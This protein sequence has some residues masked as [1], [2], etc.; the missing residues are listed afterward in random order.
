MATATAAGEGRKTAANS[1]APP[2][3]PSSSA[4][5][6]RATQERD[7]RR[8]ALRASNLETW[9]SGPS[10]PTG[11]L[12]SSLKKNTA[13]VKR[14]KQGLGLENRD[15]AIKEIA[16]LNLDKYVEEVVQM[17][18]EGLSRCSSAKDYLAAA[19]VL[20]A[21]HKRFGPSA[22]SVPLTDL[23][24]S[25][26]SPPSKAVLQ[27]ISAEQR[28]RD[29][30]SRVQR[31]KGLLRVV[32]ELA[33]VQLVGG[34]DKQRDQHASI[35]WL[36]RIIKDLLSNDREHANIPIL[37]TLLKALGATL[38]SP[39]NVA[40][41]TPAEAQAEPSPDQLPELVTF[42][43]KDRLQKLLATYFE[44]LRRRIVREHAR[45]Q[46]Q[47]RRNHEAY[48]RSGEIFEDRQQN[49]EKTTKSFEK[50]LDS[51]RQLAELLNLPMPK[52]AESVQS[53]SIGLNLDAK[54]AFER[55]D[56]DYSSG[57]LPWEDEDTRRFYEDVPDLRDQVPMDLLLAGSN[58]VLNAKLS[59][60]GWDDKTKGENDNAAEASGVA[61]DEME[62]VEHEDGDATPK[63]NGSPPGSPRS[64]LEEIAVDHDEP[65]ITPTTDT[66][67]EE[68]GS[69]SA[70]MN[71]LLMRLPELTSRD[72]IDG[73]AIEFGFLNTKANRGRMMRTLSQMYKN[74]SDLPPYYARLV[75][76]L[77]KYMPD[78]GSGVVAWL[79]DEFRV[80]HKRRLSEWTEKRA[81]NAQYLGELTKFKVCPIHVIFHCLKVCL[82]DF[83]TYTI[84]TLSILL[85]T[86]GRFL[87]RTEQT[88]ER[89]K[90]ALELLRRKRAA[91]HI[92][93][94]FLLLLD[95]AYYFCNPPERKAVEQK[96]RPPIEQY[97]RHLFYDMLSRKTLE[98]VLK[99]LRK[100]AWDD[101]AVRK[102]LF[103]AF[104]KPWRIKFGN[105]HLLA[106]LL[107]ELQTYHP[108]FVIEVLEQ[109]CEDVVTGLE[110]NV[111]Q[112]NQ[113]RVAVVRYFGELY[114]YRL[115]NSKMIFDQ[116]WSFTT[117]GHPYGRPLPGQFTPLDA[118]DDYFRIRLI[119]TLLDTCGACFD[120]GSLKRRLDSFL[121]F[122]NLY[123]LS[124]TQPLPM[125]IDFM[126]SDTLEALRPKLV[127]KTEFE[128]VAVAV[129]QMFALQRA[130]EA[131]ATTAVVIPDGGEAGEDDESDSE[132][133]EDGD[134]DSSGDEED[135]DD[136][137]E[138]DDEEG[139]EE[140]EEE[141]E[142]IE[143][144]ER[145]LELERQAEDSRRADED[146][147][148][149]LA[150]MIAESNPASAGASQANRQRNLLDAGLPVLQRGPSTP[151]GR[152]TTATMA[153]AGMGTTSEGANAGAE[154]EGHMRFSLL[155]KKGSKATT[156]DVHVPMSAAIAI[157]TRS[158]QLQDEAERRHLKELVLAYGLREDDDE[159]LSLE[160]ALR[161]QG[162]RVKTKSRS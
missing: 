5:T 144:E 134:S 120:Q 59:R 13:F 76:L 15:A 137:E 16:T 101:P 49:F 6:V 34:A 154:P 93:Q 150:K 70:K 146:F 148:R 139:D 81:R 58:P 80:I 67:P 155:S 61:G 26:L 57:R 72:A 160:D 105:V 63:A 107:F 4:A 45:L 126:L 117:F 19:E 114:N 131:P 50:L 157:Q 113:R 44:T 86:C 36:F 98:K 141:D 149:E 133:D 84:E 32:A 21:L 25:L 48:I 115:I 127:F 3:A 18:P 136:D 10:P 28:E 60:T 142:D 103:K 52:L 138:D 152:S 140:E 43:Q 102:Y 75:A 159:K 123:V 156:T 85:E 161:A 97:I 129:D 128:E 22:L 42:E 87:L 62:G 55:D 104:T 94:R 12:D 83:S 14:I 65:L 39:S 151:F 153:G 38:L 89:M 121:T 9:S 74:R 95:N 20:T 46:E 69:A 145:A 31:Q 56:E 66:T 130:N 110:S 82:D 64:V 2:A 96:K 30:A 143:A 1:D 71:V 92:D 106:I 41:P 111:F 51:S 118:P 135:D 33:L 53:S 108:D 100:M 24:G 7:K 79:N 158:K 23:L 68:P 88:S 29:E 90:N 35:D 124:K 122:F 109:A 54:S 77:N 40:G 37:I 17:V 91:T 99:L 73:A 119:C 112:F 147:D 78:I 162:I 11:A 132:D 27:A 47:D 116:L 8:A 125:E